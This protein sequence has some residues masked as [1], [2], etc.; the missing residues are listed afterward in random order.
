MSKLLKMPRLGE[1]MEEGRIVAWLV[2]PGEAF[3]RGAPLLEVE[4][5]KT[6]VEFPAL[7][8]GVLTETIAAETDT[9]AVGAPIARVEIAD[10]PDWTAGDGDDADKSEEAPGPTPSPAPDAPSPI[11]GEAPS[12]IGGEAPHR[13]RATPLARRIARQNGIELTAVNGTGRRGRIEKGDV[14]SAAGRSVPSAAPRRAPV[15]GEMSVLHD[16]A[17][18][19]IGPQ[20]GEPVLLIHGFAGDHG[21]FANIS[22]GLARAGRRAVAVDLPGHGVTSLE[23][24]IL[25]DLSP[26]LIA[27]AREAFAG[28]RPR[29][30]ASS[31]GAVP[32]VA[33]AQAIEPAALTLLAPVGLGLFIDGEF[34]D[35]MAVATSTGEVSHLLARATEGPPPLTNERLAE[36][37]ERLSSRRLLALAAALHANNR[38]RINLKPQLAKLARRIPVRVVVGHRDRLLDWREATDISP[39]I[40]VHHFPRV[41]HMPSWEAPA[42]T[43]DIVLR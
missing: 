11:G 42:E 13:V 12:P 1:T 7:G 10:G 22:S 9:V 24:K 29:I 20:T 16:I 26:N 31:M 27:F 17:H 6:V 34:L 39:L 33:V 15:R 4:T 38:Q 41:G 21:I 18:V 43:L 19:S 8:A 2:K 40:A 28:Q 32:A 5:D 35:A 30:V 14:E 36:V 25:D 37:V 3:E 23:A